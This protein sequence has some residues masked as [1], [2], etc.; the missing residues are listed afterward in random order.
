MADNI[1]TQIDMMQSHGRYGIEAISEVIKARN[2]ASIIPAF[3]MQ[4]PQENITVYTKLPTSLQRKKNAGIN[5]SG[6]V[7]EKR[8][9]SSYPH[10]EY[11][12]YD[13]SLD[14]DIQGIPGQSREQRIA[15]ER[16]NL[17]S[18]TWEAHFNRQDFNSIYGQSGQAAVLASA[19]GSN[20]FFQDYTVDADSGPGIIKW[21]DKWGLT[22]DSFKVSAGG[23]TAAELT[24]VY[25]LVLGGP[26]GLNYGTHKSMGQNE[27]WTERVMDMSDGSHMPIYENMIKGDWGLVPRS[28]YCM[29][30]IEKLSVTEAAANLDIGWMRALELMVRLATGGPP[31][32]YI[33]TETQW[34]LFEES[35]ATPETLDPTREKSFHGVPFITTPAVLEG[36][37][38]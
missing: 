21:M 27:A 2:F 30:R 35:Y 32:V 20:A 10:D 15:I 26:K 13:Q 23:T 33:S 11:I 28:L 22:S 17:T 19:G 9:F 34:N 24:S 3:Q 16:N 8:S 14:D 36:E 31:D 4:A 29:F 38:V 5:T 7:N 6:A 1:I 18:V 37:T 25:A 12:Y